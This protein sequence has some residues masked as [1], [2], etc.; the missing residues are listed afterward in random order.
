[1]DTL[2]IA[3]VADI[4]G[5]GEWVV[6]DDGVVVFRSVDEQGAQDYVDR[7]LSW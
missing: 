7:V 5:G 1:M 4:N 6:E 3:F 2:E